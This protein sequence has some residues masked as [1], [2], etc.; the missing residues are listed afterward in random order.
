VIV[1]IVLFFKMIDDLMLNGASP[2]Q[3]N[4]GSNVK[5]IILIF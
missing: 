2:M 4:Q 5:F 3:L 1:F